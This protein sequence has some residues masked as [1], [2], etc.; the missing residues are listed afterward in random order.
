MALCSWGASQGCSNALALCPL[1]LDAT[2]EP[3]TAAAGSGDQGQ[4][5]SHSM[6]LIQGEFDNPDLKRQET[7]RGSQNTME[8]ACSRT[9]SN[10]V[11]KPVDARSPGSLLSIVQERGQN[12]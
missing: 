3:T 11:S 8:V 5:E 12:E 7:K 10:M 1:T 6:Y 9:C 2:H 4:E